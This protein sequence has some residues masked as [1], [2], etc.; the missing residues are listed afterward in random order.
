MSPDSPF[1]YNMEVTLYKDGKAIDQ[2][3]SY[4]AM[5]KYSIRKGQN[6][7]TRLQLNNKDYFQFGPLDQDGGLT[8]CILHQQTKHWFMT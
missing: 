3:K 6:G 5:R 1:L 7:I 4:T 2:V 8:V